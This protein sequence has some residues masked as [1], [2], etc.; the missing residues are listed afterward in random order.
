MAA[1]SIV[2]YWTSPVAGG[3][4]KSFRLLGVALPEPPFVEPLGA[5]GP[6]LRP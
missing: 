3:E 5:R 4:G 6:L 1:Y 2:K